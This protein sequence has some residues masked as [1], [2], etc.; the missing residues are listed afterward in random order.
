MAHRLQ[1]IVLALF[2]GGVACANLDG[3]TG[4]ASSTNDS[5]VSQGRGSSSGNGADAA[6]PESGSEAGASDAA[7][8]SADA[9]SDVEGGIDYQTDPNNCGG[10][11][12]QCGAKTCVNGSCR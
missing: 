1:G 2:L 10:A 7:S 12:N 8:Q 11:G 9:G 3:L 5:A 4:G 6:A